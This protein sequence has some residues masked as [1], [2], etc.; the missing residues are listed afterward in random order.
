L[1]APDPLLRRYPELKKIADSAED[2]AGTNLPL[3]A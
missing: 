3:L 2:A 1:K